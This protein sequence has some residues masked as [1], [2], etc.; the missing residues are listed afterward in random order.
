MLQN[1]TITS[2]IPH[3][4]KLN[5]GARQV[6]FGYYVPLTIIGMKDE[7]CLDHGCSNSR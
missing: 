5:L 4:N 3:N 2:L 1:K 6:P 7:R